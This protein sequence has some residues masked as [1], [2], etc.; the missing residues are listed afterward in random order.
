MSHQ[1]FKLPELKLYIDG[2]WT[3]GGSG[4]HIDVTNPAT[5]EVL[6]ALPLASTDDID[7]ALRAASAALPAWR[8]TPSGERTRLVMA[9]AA[10]VREHSEDLARLTTLELGMRYKDALVL[11]LRAADILDWDAN[12]GRRLYGRVLPSAPGLQQ[13]VLR[14]PIGCVAS[15][16]PWN[17]SVFTPC[18][19]IGS[20]L[21]AGCT[22]ILK[23]AE[24]TPLS[25]IALVRLFARVG[26]P[27]GVL[28]L[29]FGDPA[30]VS[31]QLIESPIVRLVTFTGS[32]PVGRQLAQMAAG[33]LKPSVMELGGHAPVIVCAD[34]LLEQ[35]A[36]RLVGTKYFGAGQI[37]HTP[38]RVFVDM[39]V[40]ARFVALV[41]EKVRKLR[42]GN[43]MDDGVDMGPLLSARRVS[44]VDH[45]V[46]DAVQHGARVA[47]GGAPIEGPGFFYQPTVL[48]DVPPGAKIMM[49]EPFG[50]VLPIQTFTSLEQ[51]LEQ[52]NA[53]PYGLGGYIFTQS[54]TTAHR[55]S[56][57]LQCGM[58]GINHFGV[59][60]DGLP[61]GGVKDSGSGR[62]GGIE[63]I[64]NY[65][66]AKTVSH[67]F[68]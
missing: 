67:A 11:V 20:A 14:E 3:A 25:T 31:R 37:C 9:G 55:L 39:S 22:L 5:G 34:A 30:Q 45:L 60:T 23:A 58:V 36:D 38:S 24:E 21:A 41:E 54:A 27:R 33:M 63:G 28:N 65:T 66:V 19:K 48:T 18:R 68:L 29:V 50:P 43:G 15:F 4:R 8:D 44:A 56:S 32:V 59:S 51:A 40:H 62:E 61:F 46:R 1:K 49:E 47:C 13:F 57:A 26:I 7:R 6:G 53:V 2:E 52:A 10:L 17:G 35:A 42:V 64:A 16:A 12:E